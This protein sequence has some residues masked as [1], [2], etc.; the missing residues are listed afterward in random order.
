MGCNLSVQIGHF[1]PFQANRVHFSPGKQ[2]IKAASFSVRLLKF[3][4]TALPGAQPSGKQRGRLQLVD[5][6]DFSIQT[7]A[8]AAPAP[9]PSH[10][11]EL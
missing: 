7:G 5:V 1:Y 11:H 8:E 6:C 10:Y 2:T 3:G 9:L 4:P